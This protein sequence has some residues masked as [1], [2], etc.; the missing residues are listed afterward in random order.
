METLQQRARAIV[1]LAALK[2][3][4][5]SRWLEMDE[6][7][8]WE[9]EALRLLGCVKPVFMD[10][11]AMAAQIDEACA[12]ELNLMALEAMKSDL[13]KRAEQRREKKRQRRGER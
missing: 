12:V 7:G 6:R 4:S 1:K 10:D 11:P 13:E 5:A 8:L 9:R 3:T 2:D